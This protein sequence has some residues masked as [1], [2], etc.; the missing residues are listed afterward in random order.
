MKRIYSAFF[1]I[2]VI[3]VFNSGLS[4]A[5][6]QTRVNQNIRSISYNIQ[7]TSNGIQALTFGVDYPLSS[8]VGIIG[9]YTY[10]A[11]GYF[12]DL[13]VKC[14]LVESSTYNLSALGGYHT[15][16][17]DYSS[18]RIGLIAAKELNDYIDLS[19]GLVWILGK[20]ENR[21]G[22]E[23]GINYTLLKKLDIELGLRKLAGQNNSAGIALGVRN[24]F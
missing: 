3:L 6:Y 20:S 2:L 8:T 10:A 16:F 7:Q 12:L 18:S 5:M 15:S 22:I 11:E 9:L 24:Y 17:D 19:G 1:I 14:K 4:N 23:I 13:D 21:L